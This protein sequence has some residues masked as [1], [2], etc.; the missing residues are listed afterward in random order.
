MD[1][2]STFFFFNCMWCMLLAVVTAAPV[3]KKRHHS[4]IIGKH[5]DPS[6]IAAINTEA[7]S[8]PKNPE[9]MSDLVQD[10]LTSVKIF[11][12]E[13]QGSAE[14]VP[15]K[16]LLKRRRRR[17]RRGFGYRTTCIPKKKQMCQIFTVNGITKP[18]CL[19]VD[20]T[21]CTALD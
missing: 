8:D 3:S 18:Y 7:E 20:A 9:D 11:V 19:T 17:R 16:H 5:Q 4:T 21:E 6:F 1:L 13:I 15:V 14:N 10:I 2:Y 12:P